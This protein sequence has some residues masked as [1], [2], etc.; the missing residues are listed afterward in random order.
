MQLVEIFRQDRLRTFVIAV[1]NRANFFVYHV[2]GNVGYLLVLGYRS[3]EKYLTVLL[4]VGQGTEPLGETPLGDHVAGN[5]RG[6]LDIVGRARRH[7]VRTKNQLF[8]YSSA[9]QA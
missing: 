2:R 9:E 1:D 5:I 3:P 7:T 4:G 6:S 8:R